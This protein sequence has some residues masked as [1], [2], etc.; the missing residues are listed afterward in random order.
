VRPLCS[1]CREVNADK[2]K[3]TFIPRAQNARQIHNAEIVT[4]SSETV[5]NC[6]CLDG[7]LTDGNCIHEE[8]NRRLKRQMLI[9][10]LFSVFCYPVRYVNG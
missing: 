1:Y 10:V 7:T 9:A 6:K 2:T 4:K 5:A 8:I 3:C